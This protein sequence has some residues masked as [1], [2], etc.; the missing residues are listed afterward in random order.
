MNIYGF[1]LNEKKI[2]KEKNNYFGRNCGTI[3]RLKKILID[4]LL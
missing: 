4:E 3:S 2:L 1:K